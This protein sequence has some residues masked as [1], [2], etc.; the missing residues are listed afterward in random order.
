MKNKLISILVLS[1]LLIT[2]DISGAPPQGRGGGSLTVDSVT[3]SILDDGTDSPLVGECVTV[4]STDTNKFEYITCPGA[5]GGDSITVDTVAVVDP[6]FADTGDINFT[7]TANTISGDVQAN[8]VALTTDTTGNYAAGDAEAG[9]ALTGDSA[10]GFFSVG[11]IADAQISDALTIALGAISTSDIILEEQGVSDPTV[12]GDIEWDTTTETVKIG[13]DGIATYEFFPGAHTTDTTLNLA[14]VETITG[15]WVNTTNPWADNEVANNIT[16]DLATT[17]TALAANG[18]NCAAGN[19]PLGVDASGAVESCTADVDTDTQLSQEQVE[20]FAG[21]LI[22]DGTGTH[23]GITITYQDVTGDVDFVVGNAPTATALAA[24]GANCAAGSYP[25]GVDASGVT[26]SCT[27]ATTEIDSAISTHA[28]LSEAHQSLV[29]LGGTGTYLSLLGQAITVDPITESDI[30]DLAH[31]TLTHHPC[32][33]VV[34]HTTA[35]TVATAN[36]GDFRI[37]WTG[38]IQSVRGYVN[39]AGTTG[40]MTVDLN[41]NGTTIMTTNKISIETAEKSSKTAVTQPTLTTTA[42]TDDDI[43]TVDIDAIQTGTA[44]KGLSVCLKITE[45]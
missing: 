12:D 31:T 8:S 1:L 35:V 3:T 28:A 44:A 39:T 41:L 14:G 33:R 13:D 24:N 37:P 38:T 19:Y 11:E 9:A 36:G 25:L 17:A 29:T 43:I 6:D 10:T 15:N 23:T 22:G 40:T 18:A 34:G 45:P 30:S 7:N 27:D 32:F 42:V 2:G 20:D 26:E 5:A 16:I 21:A 4:D